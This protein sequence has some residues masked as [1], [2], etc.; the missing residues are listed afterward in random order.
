MQILSMS[1]IAKGEVIARFSDTE[2]SR[3]LL[4]DSFK[5]PHEVY[6]SVSDLRNSDY[7]ISS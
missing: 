7:S 1:T 3:N 2:E 5:F 4:E 6:H